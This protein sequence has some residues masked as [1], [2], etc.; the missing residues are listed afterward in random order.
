VSEQALLMTSPSP[1]RPSKIIPTMMA[2]AIM[3]LF[4]ALTIL[5]FPSLSRTTTEASA[6]SDLR[7][8]LT[9][10]EMYHPPYSAPPAY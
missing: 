4:A 8:L 10:L 3:G 1:E 2:L 7:A 9:A 6:I 5:D